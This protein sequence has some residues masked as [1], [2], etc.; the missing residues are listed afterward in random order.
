MARQRPK[1]VG[2]PSLTDEGYWRRWRRDIDLIAQAVRNLV[3]DDHLFRASMAMHRGS[4]RT[5]KGTTGYQWIL[6]TYGRDAVVGVRRMLDRDWRSTSLVN[7]LRLLEQHNQVL[8]LER[9][10]RPYLRYR[11]A[12]EVWRRTARH[13]FR[14][15]IDSGA[16]YLPKR[17]VRED[18]ATLRSHWKKLDRV[19]HK[20]IAHYEPLRS[21]GKE[22]LWQDVHDAVQALEKITIRYI[23]L[24][25]QIDA[26]CSLLPSQYG[27]G[28]DLYGQLVAFWGRRRRSRRRGL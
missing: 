8:S 18:L 20:R 15:L 22:P 19:T 25:R 16:A 12:R 11:H 7:L 24:L 27:K 28:G 14:D 9:F 21:I 4:A 2:P 13:E 5:K 3:I 10:T 23:W 17:L 1:R 6:R 26:R